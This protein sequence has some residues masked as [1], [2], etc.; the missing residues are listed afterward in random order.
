MVCLIQGR[1]YRLDEE[2]SQLTY[3]T[4]CYLND[5]TATAC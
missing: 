2:T 4:A 1:V 5:R 3:N